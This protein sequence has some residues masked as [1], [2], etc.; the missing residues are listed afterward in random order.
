MRIEDINRATELKEK[1]MQTKIILADLEAFDNNIEITLTYGSAFHR[2]I[3][4]SIREPLYHMLKDYY[5]KELDDIL[6]EIT[7]L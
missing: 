4:K 6:Q 1:Y 5:M 3:P 2:P 7:N